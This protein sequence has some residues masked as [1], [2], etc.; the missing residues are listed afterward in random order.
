MP[1]PQSDERPYHHGD[2]RRAI[3]KAAL[4]I[5]RETQNLELSLREIARRAGVSHN[6]PYK[7]FADKRELLA[8]ISAAGFEMLTNRMA[9]ERTR[10][11]DPRGQLFAMLRAYID[12]GVEN[13]ALY[14][15][16]FGGYLGGPD[17]SRPAIELAEAEK[18][19][20]LLA[21]VIVAGGL[22]RTILDAPRNERKIAGAILACWSLVHGLTLLL[23]DGLV[24]PKQKS[25]ALADRLV[26][27]MLDGLAA[28][29]PALPPGTWLGPQAPQ[30]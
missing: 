20:A 29:L 5:L 16:M 11:S 1:R 13:P 10:L 9:H 2:L 18:T 30:Q 26:Q 14:G 12:H 22:G 15:L 25:G 3:V 7:H 23:V 28:E 6:A 4:E 27:S 17:R 24:G 8:A 19:K 21:G